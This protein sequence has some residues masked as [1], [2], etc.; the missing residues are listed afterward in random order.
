M[1]S[2]IPYFVYLMAVYVLIARHPLVPTLAAATLLW[3][4]AAAILVTAWMRLHRAGA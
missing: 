2:L 4:V 3:L 1:W